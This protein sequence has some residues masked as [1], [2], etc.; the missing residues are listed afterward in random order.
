M[1]FF[2]YSNPY[3]SIFLFFIFCF[4]ARDFTYSILEKR[5]LKK[6]IMGM[7]D[8]GKKIKKVGVWQVKGTGAACMW[9]GSEVMFKKK[10][11]GLKRKSTRTEKRKKD[12]STDRREEET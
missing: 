2:Y 3:F 9:I 12:F 5:L 6:M 1:F 4:V 7:D 11:G 10:K 8:Y